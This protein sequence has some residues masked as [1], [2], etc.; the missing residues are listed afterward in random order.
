MTYVTAQYN[1]GV[2]YVSLFL[3]WPTIHMA[4]RNT[5]NEMLFAAER[6]GD[7]IHI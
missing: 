3:V 1:S 4:S 7:G 6:N 5:R 2:S